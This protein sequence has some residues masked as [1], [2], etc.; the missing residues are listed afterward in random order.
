MS[1]IFP[2]TL[3]LILVACKKFEHN[4]ELPK[5]PDRCEL[6][7]YAETLNK[8]Y[9]GKP[10]GAL[11]YVNIPGTYI[12]DSLKIELEHVFLNRGPYIDSTV[13]FFK[14]T[15]TYYHENIPKE[16]II[17]LTDSSG[18]FKYVSSNDYFYAS[19]DTLIM[20]SYYY[21]KYNYLRYSYYGSPIP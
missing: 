19:P 10:A 3:F 18:Y 13:M 2:L 5:P 9:V 1:R 14:M 17:Q 11:A 20:Y 8:T 12:K 4:G 6:C 21:G 16:T 7:D 15:R